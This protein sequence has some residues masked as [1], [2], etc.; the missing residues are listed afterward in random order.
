MLNS[1]SDVSFDRLKDEIRFDHVS[2]S[3]KNTNK[4]V[5]ND[6]SLVIPRG[7]TTAIVGPS[8]SGK[9]TLAK[10][11]LRLYDPDEGT[12][13]VD[14][15]DIR[16]LNLRE[17]RHK[18]G[19]VGQEPCLFNESIRDNLLNKNPD[20]SD[21]QMEQAL[22]TATALEFV[23]AL[24]HGIHTDVGALGG[25]ISGGQKQR[26]AIARALMSNPEVLIFDEATSALDK[27]NEQKLQMAINR[28][29][30]GTDMTKVV[31]AHRLSTVRHADK[32]V[33]VEEGRITAE[34]THS[35]LMEISETYRNYFKV[36]KKLEEDDQS[37]EDSE[38]Q[39]E[40]SVSNIYLISNL[41]Y[42]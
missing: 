13:F 34:G 12:I 5:L 31:I 33:V 41:F 4:Q 40:I 18:V 3:Y 36:Q 15:I 17:Y 39:S 20:A 27:E 19:Y 37:D 8:G 6:V 10:M 26:I 32:I 38:D 35:E 14:N 23:Q 1:E 29:I 11:L 16:D 25:K 22:Q 2:Y 28:V 30:D 24:Q 9:S 7:K 21:Q 42:S